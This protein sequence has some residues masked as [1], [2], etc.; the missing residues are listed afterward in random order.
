MAG[1]PAGATPSDPSSSAT[2]PDVSRIVATDPGS[3]WV[4]IGLDDTPA[5]GWSATWDPTGLEPGP[6]WIRL[7]VVDEQGHSDVDFTEVW[8]IG[9]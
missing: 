5:D 9:G 3:E 8:L 1:G 6:Y 7:T 4:Q 2:T